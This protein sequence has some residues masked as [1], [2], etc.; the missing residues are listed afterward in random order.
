MGG[1]RRH[2][3]GFFIKS[4]VK[5]REIVVNHSVGWVPSSTSRWHHHQRQYSNYLSMGQREQGSKQARFSSSRSRT[6][7]RKFRGK[8]NFPN[9]LK[10][11]RRRKRNHQLRKEELGRKGSWKS[12]VTIVSPLASYSATPLAMAVLLLP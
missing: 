11:E 1:T 12:K 2:G 3:N 8:W 9:A 6:R 4:V 5:S 10:F 7:D